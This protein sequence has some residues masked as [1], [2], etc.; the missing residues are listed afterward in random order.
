MFLFND[1][2]IIAQTLSSAKHTRINTTMIDLDMIARGMFD[3]LMFSIVDI[4]INGSTI[5]LPNGRWAF[6]FGWAANVEI[7]TRCKWFISFSAKYKTFD[8]CA[9]KIRNVSNIFI[10]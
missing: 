7:L 6:M 8:G 4:P 1:V 9:E 2:W 10:F 5:D 3:I